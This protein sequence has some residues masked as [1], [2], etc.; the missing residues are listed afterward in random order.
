MFDVSGQTVIR[1]EQRTAAG[2][3]FCMRSHVSQGLDV[4]LQC[5]AAKSDDWSLMAIGHRAD[6]TNSSVWRRS[7]LHVLEA[8]VMFVSDF[9]ALRSRDFERAVSYRRCVFPACKHSVISSGTFVY[10]IMT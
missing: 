6:A 5:A 3:L 2:L 1:C 4:A 8:S 9:D 10:F 7:K